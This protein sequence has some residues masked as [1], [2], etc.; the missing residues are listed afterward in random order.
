MKF[1]LYFLSIIFILF[2]NTSV[3]ETYIA[4]QHEI[5]LYDSSYYKSLHH[6]KIGKSMTL[7]S[8]KT[9]GE[10]GFGENINEGTAL[11]SGASYEYLRAGF[12]KKIF[13]NIDVKVH[14]ESKLNNG[15]KDDNE[16]Q[17]NTKYTF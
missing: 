6:I 14:F 2:S 9:F 10:L 8:F 4:T 5:K 11:G 17:I 3:A 16:L 13:T 15:S 1:N 7:S 12:S